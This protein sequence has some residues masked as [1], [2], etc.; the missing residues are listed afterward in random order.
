[1]LKSW[2]E[3][4]KLARLYAAKGKGVPIPYSGRNRY[5]PGPKWFDDMPGNWIYR[6]RSK[7]VAKINNRD[8]RRMGDPDPHS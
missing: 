1:M 7:H 6:F 4:I 8:Q 3:R 2:R 5:K